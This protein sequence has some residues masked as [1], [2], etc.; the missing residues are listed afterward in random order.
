MTTEQIQGLESNLTVFHQQ[1]STELAVVILPALDGE[2]I[3][4]LATEIGQKR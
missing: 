4:M 1:T 3:S 2:D